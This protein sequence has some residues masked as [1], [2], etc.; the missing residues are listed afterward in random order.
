MAPVRR[1]SVWRR[2]SRVSRQSVDSYG[3]VTAA[4]CSLAG[5]RRRRRR[6]VLR[7]RL[8]WCTL[9]LHDSVRLR[10]VTDA[11]AA[12]NVDDVDS[13]H[14]VVA[15]REC[16]STAVERSDS[17]VQ[18]HLVTFL[19]CNA[20][21]DQLAL[22]LGD[23]RLQTD[24]GSLLPS[25]TTSLKDDT[26]LLAA[27]S[28]TERDKQCVSALCNEELTACS[29]ESMSGNSQCPRHTTQLC[30]SKLRQT[31]SMI[32]LLQRSCRIPRPVPIS[33]H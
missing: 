5:R 29:H 7:L 1:C 3:S 12:V 27:P 8:C 20:L 14:A 32:T 31:T 15:G 18:R 2:P 6:L 11:A 22:Q 10:R 19:Y 21:V 26:Q 24:V 28:A 23:L 33:Q 13:V 30:T 17:G 25:S 16:T 4:T 9:P